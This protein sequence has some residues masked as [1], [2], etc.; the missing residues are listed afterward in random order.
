MPQLLLNKWLFIGLL[1]ICQRPQLVETEEESMRYANGKGGIVGNILCGPP[2][3]SIYIVSQVI[4]NVSLISFNDN[5]LNQIVIKHAVAKEL[6]LDFDFIKIDRTSCYCQ[7]N[8]ELTVTSTATFGHESLTPIHSSILTMRTT[9]LS[10]PSERSC[11][12]RSQLLLV[13]Y[14][15]AFPDLRRFNIPSQSDGQSALVSSL[16]KSVTSG[17]FQTSLQRLAM[18]DGE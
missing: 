16:N 2:N 13:N 6:L 7:S 10:M 9:Q 17:S 8:I 15:I 3:P 5:S 1:L 11:C 12:D 14:S 4:G 18:E